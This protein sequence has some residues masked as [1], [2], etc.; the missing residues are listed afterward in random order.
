MLFIT[1]VCFFP[2]YFTQ[3]KSPSNTDLNNSDREPELNDYDDHSKNKL[4][5]RTNGFID[6]ET[7]DHYQYEEISQS[8]TDSHIVV[9]NILTTETKK[10]Q[11]TKIPV[12]HGPDDSKKKVVVVFE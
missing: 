4:L 1:R 11:K 2:D 8:A 3:D 5:H 12:D 10:P 9:G 6:T 7:V